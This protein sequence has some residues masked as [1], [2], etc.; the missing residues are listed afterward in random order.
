M[1]FESIALE[2]FKVVAIE[3]KE[4]MTGL[5][6]TIKKKKDSDKLCKKADY[7]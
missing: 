5:H 7:S 3:M 2:T 4:G 1:P 6:L